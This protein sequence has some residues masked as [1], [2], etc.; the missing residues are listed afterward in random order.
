[1]LVSAGPA[2]DKAITKATLT[3]TTQITQSEAK[4]YTKATLTATQII[5]S[6]AKA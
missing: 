3:A 1:M 2:G 6:E 5:Q 4:A